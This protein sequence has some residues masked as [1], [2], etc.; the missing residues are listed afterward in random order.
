MPKILFIWYQR[1][2]PIPNGGDQ[3]SCR[4]YALCQ[5]VFGE[6]NVAS[7]YIHDGKNYGRM[8]VA[9]F[10]FLKGYYYGITPS[11][12]RMIVE[13]AQSYDYVFIDRSLFGVLAKALKECG[14]KGRIVAHFHNVE[15]QYFDQAKLP[16]WLPFRNV[17]VRCADQNDRWSMQFADK[18]IALN[19]R[20]DEELFRLY[21]RH[22]DLLLPIALPDVAENQSLEALTSKKPL[23]LT[24]GS[25]FAPNNEGILW[26]IKNVLPH[27]DATYKVVGKNMHRLKEE[28][29]DLFENIEV[30][31][32]AASLEP[33]FREA[34]VM[35]LPI[36]SGSGMKVKTCESLMYGKNI[37]G[38]SEAFEGYDAEYDKIGGLCD[39]AEQFIKKIRFFGNHPQPRFN[40]YARAIYRANYCYEVV[41]D[42]FAHLFDR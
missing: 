23:C 26:F 22:A 40:Q 1:P 27:V 3:C 35:I 37:L 17:I 38:T 39:T 29:P 30:V 32:N 20:D 31:S 41:A 16:K 4:N 11:R 42:K 7:I 2:Q 21:G 10:L 28:H 18:V 13:E 15:R 24:I 33:Y 34:D 5:Q 14:Y 6:S 19:K 8:A 12:I 25:Y 9:P 36:F